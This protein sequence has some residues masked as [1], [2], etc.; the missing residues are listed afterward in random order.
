MMTQA[1]YT[2]LSGI[3][4]NQRAI[5]ITSDN[6]ANIS[7]VG[8]R[9]VNPEFTTLFE[10]AIN[11]PIS[12]DEVGLGTR[13]NANAFSLE[14]GSIQ[15]T[16]KS[17]DL[18]IDGDGWFGVAKDNIVYYTRAGDFVFDE[19][20]DLITTDGMYVLGTMADNI[21]GNTLIKEVNETKLG[22]IASQKTLRFP[23]YLKYPPIPTQN[24]QFFGNLG[25]EDEPRTLGATVVD[26][27]NNKNN[28][29]LFFTKSKEQVPPGIQW[30]VVATTQSLDGSKIYDTKEGKLFFDEHGALISHNLTTIDNNGTQVN[31]DLGSEFG[32]II[33]TN[34]PYT[35]GSSKSDGTI[36][37]DLI[38]YEINRN[39][40]VIAT[41]T[42]GKQSSVGKIA[43]YHFQ[44]DQGLER[45]SGTRYAKSSNS[46][47]AFFYKN[48]IGENILGAD[49][50]N[51]RLES[52]NVNMTNA[53]TELI[54]YQR[55]FDANGK[56]VTTADEMIQK[57]LSMDS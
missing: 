1:Y 53:L 52:S 17:T 33:A 50:M 27:Y 46:G 24:T 25:I 15:I 4:S 31:I 30:D 6:I 10:E 45:V 16:D 20:N 48:G 18:A 28:L 7:T 51:F 55:S 49:V 42:N 43:L 5:D 32:G 26:K 22:D 57:A 44:N 38:G 56:V 23:K 36:G 34:T 29:K 21:N 11:T 8:F 14:N 2:G 3:L 54:V 13:V 47:D 12:S 9:G 37:G 41:F 39:A 40:E 19:N 35:P